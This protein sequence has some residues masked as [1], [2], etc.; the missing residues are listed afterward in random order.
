M[1]NK[2][3]LLGAIEFMG[4][5][6]VRYWNLRYKLHFPK[7]IIIETSKDR[8]QMELFH[9]F[10]INRI[11]LASVNRMDNIMKAFGWDAC[12]QIVVF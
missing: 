3:V 7:W 5:R 2:N 9:D 10:V 4:D 8:F 6:G 11:V 12:W 1:S